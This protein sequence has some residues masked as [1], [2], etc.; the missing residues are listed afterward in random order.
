MPIALKALIIIGSMVLASLGLTITPFFVAQAC[1]IIV[2]EDADTGS[3]VPNSNNGLAQLGQV[4][5]DPT[6]WKRYFYMKFDLGLLPYG[7]VINT[8]HLYTTV[9]YVLKA[10]HYE[11]TRATSNSWSETGITWSNQPSITIGSPDSKYITSGGYLIWA[12]SSYVVDANNALKSDKKITMV[13]VPDRDFSGEDTAINIRTKQH[14]SGDSPALGVEYTVP[15][16]SLTISV[17]DSKGQPVQG[18]KV[19]TPFIGLTDA[20]GIAVT[21]MQAGSY[22]VKIDYQG[23]I[24]TQSLAL[25]SAKTVSFTIPYF[26]LTIKVIDAKGQ[27]VKDA[28]IT[29]PVTGRTDATG[30]FSTELRTGTY[31]VT[32]AVGDQTRSQSIFLASSKTVTFDFGEVAYTSSIRV[33]DQVGNP[34]AATLKIGAITAACDNN[35]F[36][37]ISIPQ[38]STTIQAEMKVGNK[39]Y[40]STFETISVTAPISK[41]IT[42]NRRF[43][44]QFFIN[45]TDS[46]AG[47]GI[48][49][50]VSSKETVNIKVSR[51]YGEGY[52]LDATYQMSYEA[53]PAI[54]LQ[55]VNVVNDGELYA[56]IDAAGETAIS[57]IRD[58]P[59][60]LPDI[61]PLRIAP[62]YYLLLG[63]SFIVV[64]VAAIVAVR[65]RKK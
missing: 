21:S 60:T 55:V 3:T 4:G 27:P 43:W 10:G 38:G 39:T 32:A 16:Y 49:I 54:A 37:T 20:N 30:T 62:E 33:R 44:W 14:P 29:N 1:R 22:T 47:E 51:G 61:T 64:I 8:M 25:D 26:A 63:F 36:A 56:T 48:V 50:A 24:Q 13:I 15:D 17:K 42:I 65:R 9:D 59:I 12:V 46:T 53:S 52:L 58:N 28:V 18:A 34:L 5:V 31:T 35:G 6:G 7:A 57:H 45:Y 41:E 23:F 40:T 19:V 11:V 2:S